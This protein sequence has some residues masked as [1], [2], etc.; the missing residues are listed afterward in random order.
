MSSLLLNKTGLGVRRG[1]MKAIHKHL[2]DA[3]AFSTQP[4]MD[5]FEVAPENWIQWGG[6]HRRAFDEL[7]EAHPFVSHGL[8]L[9]LGGPDPLRY[10]FIKEVKQFLDEKRMLIYS[11]H[12]SYSSDG[13][14]MYDLMPMPLTYA[15][16]DYVADRIQQVQD[17]LGRRIAVENVSYYATPAQE[18]SEFDFFLSVVKKADCDILLDVNNVYVNSINHRY[19]A[20]SFIAGLPSERIA[21]MHIAGH[22]EESETLI[23]DT[24]G[25]A[26]IPKVWDLLKCAYLHHGAL[27]TLLERDFNYPAFA[28]LASE[29]QQIRLTQNQMIRNENHAIIS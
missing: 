26:V 20:K 4:A 19:D 10:D 21:Y 23:V 9:S 3:K 18:M 28:E 15:M 8:S 17:I 27:G 12:L 1:L 16:V 7:T 24:H 25:A 22:Y 13:G 11:E 2:E 29:L 6:A 14:Q 5:F